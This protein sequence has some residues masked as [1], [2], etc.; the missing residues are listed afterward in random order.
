MLKED[1]V[2]N[3]IKRAYEKAKEDLKKEMEHN[4]ILREPTPEEVYSKIAGVGLLMANDVLNQ[5]EETLQ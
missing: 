5:N 3:V 4:G 2:Q 1:F